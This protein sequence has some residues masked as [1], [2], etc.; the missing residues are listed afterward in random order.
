MAAQTRRGG[1]SRGIVA[2]VWNQGNSPVNYLLGLLQPILSAE[3]LTHIETT[4]APATVSSGQLSASINQQQIQT[5][6][7]KIAPERVSDKISEPF[8]TGLNIAG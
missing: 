8:Q 3:R 6:L 2:H 7:L 4:I 5:H 1:I